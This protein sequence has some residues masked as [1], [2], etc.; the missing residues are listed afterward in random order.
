MQKKCEAEKKRGKME[1][2]EAS[3]YDQQE[4]N[5]LAGISKST[6]LFIIYPR[7]RNCPS[8]ENWQG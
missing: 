1:E 6:S 2:G 5:S 8:W 7:T 4:E 3:I